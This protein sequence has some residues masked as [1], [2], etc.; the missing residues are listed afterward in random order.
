MRPKGKDN[1]AH[2]V[3][4]WDTQHPVLRRGCGAVFHKLE[5]LDGYG[6]YHP[7]AGPETVANFAADFR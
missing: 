4:F 5:R 6:Y 7:C 1:R 2:V 3:W